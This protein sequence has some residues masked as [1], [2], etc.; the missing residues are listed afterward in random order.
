MSYIKFNPDEL[1]L[2]KR[3]IIDMMD[4]IESRWKKDKIHNAHFI[5]SLEAMKIGVRLMRE[6]AI[7]ALWSEI[8]N[9]FNELLYEN[10]MSKARG[11]NENWAKTLDKVKKKLSQDAGDRVITD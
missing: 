5:M 10:A 7:T 6:N 3:D 2:T 8:V 9:G 4:S 1:K 11:E